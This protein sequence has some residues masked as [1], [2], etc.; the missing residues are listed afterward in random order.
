[1]IS[2]V[3]CC[4]SVKLCAIVLSGFPIAT[5][6]CCDQD[7]KVV[8]G[9]TFTKKHTIGAVHCI[10]EGICC[11]LSV[12]VALNVRFTKYGM[13]AK[14][15]THIYVARTSNG[16]V[17]SIEW[18]RWVTSTMLVNLVSSWLYL[19]MVMTGVISS[20]GLYCYLLSR[21]EAL[22]TCRSAFPILTICRMFV[23]MLYAK[24]RE[25]KGVHACHHTETS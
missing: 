17:I 7:V 1:M 21:C 24:A 9:A 14:N 20:S 11:N 18:F 16:R 12:G 23:E 5:R 10:K 15:S 19:E 2:I 3:A 4:H 6:W 13:C 8:L 22:H 25:K